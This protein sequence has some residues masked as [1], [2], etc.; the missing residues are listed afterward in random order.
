MRLATSHGNGES[1]DRTSSSE[2]QTQVKPGQNTVLDRFPG[3]RKQIQTLRS[4]F[5]EVKFILS[6]SPS[7]TKFKTVK[8]FIQRINRRVQC[9]YNYILH[10]YI[11]IQTIP[12]FGG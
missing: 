10:T 8:Y 12:I 2:P 1:V 9:N 5:G 4:L 3:R 6:Q 11:K 7:T